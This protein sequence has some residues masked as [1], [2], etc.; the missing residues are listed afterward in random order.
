MMHYQDDIL[1]FSHGLLDHL[2]MQQKIYDKMNE[3]KLIFKI[4]KAHI[5]YKTQRV[6]GQLLY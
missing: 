1:N 6:L 4:A 2:T 3:F 5:N